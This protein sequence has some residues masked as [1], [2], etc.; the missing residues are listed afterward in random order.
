MT[1][2]KGYI[3]ALQDGCYIQLHFK[4]PSTIDE[5]WISLLLDPFVAVVTLVNCLSVKLATTIQNV[6]CFCKLLAIGII[7]SG[8]IYKL[9]Q[10]TYVVRTYASSIRANSV[11]QIYRRKTFKK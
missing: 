4:R 9:C 5:L 3:P 1:W 8:G 11:L 6:F 7:I 10:G 2:A